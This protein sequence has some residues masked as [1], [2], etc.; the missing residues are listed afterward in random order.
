MNAIKRLP[1][2]LLVMALFAFSKPEKKETKPMLVVIDVAHGGKD[3]GI[4]FENISEKEIV[5]KIASKI[6]AL[7]EDANIKIELNRAE[8]TFIS[9]QERVSKINSLKPDIVISLHI[10]G[11]KSDNESGLEIYTVKGNNESLK[12]A[13]LLQRDF[14]NFN[15]GKNISLKDGRFYLLKNID[16]PAVHMELGYLTNTNDRKIILSDY[17]QE[18]IAKFILNSLQNYK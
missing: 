13:E 12:F 7:N 16:S 18:E 3:S 6:V 10:N 17:G 2:F 4:I 14:Y 15:V 9:L 1:L 8:D 11:S 5:S